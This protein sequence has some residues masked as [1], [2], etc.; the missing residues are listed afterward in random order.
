MREVQKAFIPIEKNEIQNT[1]TE[2]LNVY[3]SNIDYDII[4]MGEDNP[5]LRSPSAITDLPFYQTKDTL[6][7][8]EQ[9]K[10]FIKN[11]EAR[12]RRS[13]EYKTYK[14]Y[15]MSLGFDHCQIMGNIESEE[16]VDIELHHNILTLFDDCILIT[17][18]VLNTIGYISSFDLI[19]LLI[20]EHFSN[21]IPCCFLSKTAHQMFTD[22]KDSYIQPFKFAKEIIS[23]NYFFY[24]SS[25]FSFFFFFF[26]LFFLFKSEIFTGSPS[27]VIVS[28]IDLILLKSTFSQTLVVLKHKS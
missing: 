7:D 13:R 4:S 23:K 11:A 12:F 27:I 5:T 25:L 3:N 15:L 1:N 28:S 24:K 14:A 20:N 9:Y 2:D 16:G 6:T 19:Q 18:H 21:R 8:P 10:A 22:N 17:E 26:F